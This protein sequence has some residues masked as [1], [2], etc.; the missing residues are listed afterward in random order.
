MQISSFAAQTIKIVYSKSDLLSH[1]TMN[2][3]KYKVVY[4]VKL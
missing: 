4:C 1:A 3:N 2:C